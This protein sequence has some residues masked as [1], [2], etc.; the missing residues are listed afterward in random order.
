MLLLANQ[1]R[2]VNN[3]FLNTP[4][5]KHNKEIY[6]QAKILFNL[7]DKTFKKLFHKK[8]IKTDS[9]RSDIE[10]YEKSIAERTKLRRKKSNKIKEKEQNINNEFLKKYFNYQSPSNMYNTEKHSNKKR[11]KNQVKVIESGLIDLQ[12]DIETTSKD[13]VNIIEEMN[14]IV[15]MVQLILYFN[16]DDQQGKGLK[17]LTPN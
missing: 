1:N 5:D 7:R 8:I 16:N 10:E 13:D 11:K 12:K 15:D 6:L 17:I 2:T 9:G 3:I 14:K 4:K